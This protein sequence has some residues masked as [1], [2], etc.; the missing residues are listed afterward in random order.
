MRIIILNINFKIFIIYI[1]VLKI[2]NIKIAIFFL[3]NAIK[4]LKINKTF[5]II[6]M[7]YSNCVIIFLLKF[8]IKLLK[9]IN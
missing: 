4:L 9:Y 6:F 8:I 5:I 7:K 3:D 2:K 1:I